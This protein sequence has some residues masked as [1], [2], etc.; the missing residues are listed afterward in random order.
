MASEMSLTKTRVVVHT[1]QE[2][3][4][5]TFEVNFKVVMHFD[6]TFGNNSFFL[7][8]AIPAHSGPERGRRTD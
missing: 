5:G 4:P 2:V 6:F 3:C 1:N 7:L 8:T